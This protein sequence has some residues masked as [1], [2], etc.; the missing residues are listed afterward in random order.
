MCV[1]CC[2][3]NKAT[4]PPV[5]LCGV[6][7]FVVHRTPP[8]RRPGTRA[9]THAGD[10]GPH[11]RRE[12]RFRTATA[13]VLRRRRFVGDCAPVPEVSDAGR[14]AARPAA[15]AVPRRSVVGRLRFGGADGIRRVAPLHSV[16]PGTA[17]RDQVLHHRRRKMDLVRRGVGWRTSNCQDPSI[18]DMAKPVKRA[19]VRRDFAMESNCFCIS[20]SNA[21]HRLTRACPRAVP[22][23]LVG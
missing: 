10:G 4:I 2:E 15:A 19:T 18:S 12:R 20:G 1:K 3:C 7:F 21:F 13:R 6:L 22:T 23:G 5:C 14:D 16:D 11:G 17:L 9:P 8:T